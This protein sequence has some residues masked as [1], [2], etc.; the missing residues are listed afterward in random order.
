M[1]VFGVPKC[2]SQEFYHAPKPCCNIRPLKNYDFQDRQP[3]GR[4]S[5]EGRDSCEKPTIHLYAGI[6]GEAVEDFGDL[7]KK[8]TVVKRWWRH[9]LL[10]RDGFGYALFG[11]DLCYWSIFRG[12][13]NFW[14][15]L[16]TPGI[17]TGACH[18]RILRGF[19][20]LCKSGFGM[21]SGLGLGKTTPSVRV[22]PHISEVQLSADGWF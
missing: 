19:S 1:N 20:D 10:G 16:L 9:K 2:Y 11:A 8:K 14:H 13:R 7:L 3:A 22:I 17:F 6:H 15:R 5:G 12:C 18:W 4:L 21:G